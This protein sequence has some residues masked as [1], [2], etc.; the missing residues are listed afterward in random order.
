MRAA[1]AAMYH[2]KSSGRDNSQVFTADL[3]VATRRRLAIANGLH[4]A[5]ER[6]QFTLEYQP[7]IDL[8]SGRIP[9]VEALVRWRT[10]ELGQVPPSEFI[11]IAEETGSIAPLGE[12]VLREAC[13]QVM[14]WREAMAPDLRLAV[15]V[16]PYQF[17]RP[18]FADLVSSVLRESRLPAAELEIEI[19]EGT[20]MAYGSQNSAVLERLADKGVCLAVDDFGTGYSSLAYLRRFPIRCLKID[21][22]FIDGVGYDSNDAAIV[23]AVIAMARSMQLRVVAEGVETAEQVA[24]LK[25]HRCWGAQGFHYGKPMSAD[26]FVEILAKREKALP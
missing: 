3:N 24:F 18:G 2:A 20:L 8:A 4:E 13:F 7:Q 9:A 1:D 15:N 21:R 22:S 6:R 23:A 26:A 5:V 19:T 11:G 10:P 25:R 16:S 12:W 14:Q 17:R